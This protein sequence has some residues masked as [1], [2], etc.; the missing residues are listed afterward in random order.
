ML[1]S[2]L[3]TWTLSTSS[4]QTFWDSRK[5]GEAAA[6]ERCFPGSTSKFPME[7]TIWNSCY[8]KTR[9]IQQSEAARTIPACRYPTSQ[10]VLLLSRP[11]PTTRHTAG[12]SRLIW[13]SIAS[14]R[15][16][17]LI[18]MERAPRSWS[19]TPLMANRPLPRLLRLPTSVIRGLE[20]SPPPLLRNRQVGASPIFCRR[21]SLFDKCHSCR[22]LSR[23]FAVPLNRELLPLQAVVLRPVGHS[24]S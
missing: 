23:S 19:R 8:S 11:T 7:M 5:R 10:R 2:S 16:I 6:Q 3:P 9:P 4:T 21:L 14:G 15:Q 24:L 17:S 13:E 18:L 22:M 1:G 12:L 20:V